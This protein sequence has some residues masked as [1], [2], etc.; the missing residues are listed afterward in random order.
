[1]KRRDIFILILV[2]AGAGLLVLIAGFLYLAQSQGRPLTTTAV[3]APAPAPT[4]PN[5]FQVTFAENTALQLYPIAEAAAR[6]WQADARLVSA[7]ATWRTTAIDQVGKPTPW[8]F[9]FYSV[10]ARRSYFVTILPDGQVNAR[11][12]FLT[13]PNPPGLLP[14]QRWAVDS[15]QAIAAWL[16][17]GGGAFL[18]ENPGLEVSAILSYQRAGDGLFWHVT[19]LNQKNETL[20]STTVDAQSGAVVELV[21]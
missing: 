20:V 12:H 3:E 11:Q 21:R 1:M 14:A 6:S 17:A 16:N 7:E 9:R 15:N 18:G 4:L 2:W 5:T 19:G 13:E 8:S 10:A